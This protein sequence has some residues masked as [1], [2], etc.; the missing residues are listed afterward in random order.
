MKLICVGMNAE[1]N[2][3]SLVVISL[4]ANL[5]FLQKQFLNRIIKRKLFLLLVMVQQ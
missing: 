2:H 4:T 3:Q 5:S 1:E